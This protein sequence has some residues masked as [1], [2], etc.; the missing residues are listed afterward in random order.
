MHFVYTRNNDCQRKRVV[1]CELALLLL[2]FKLFFWF[3][4]CPKVWLEV[5]CFVRP[6]III[7]IIIIIE[8]HVTVVC[9]SVCMYVVCHTRAPC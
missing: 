7:I 2:F 4:L 5:W 9:P 6:I 8:T 3:F 1:W